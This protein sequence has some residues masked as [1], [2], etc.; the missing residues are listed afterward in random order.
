ML[1]PACDRVLSPIDGYTL[2]YVSCLDQLLISALKA[3]N[4]R[5][6]YEEAFEES[7]RLEFCLDPEKQVLR[8]WEPVSFF[9]TAALREDIRKYD[10]GPVIFF[11]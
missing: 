1:L 5:S 6:V 3:V 11:G 8:I 2:T 7:R 10:L 9:H 4:L